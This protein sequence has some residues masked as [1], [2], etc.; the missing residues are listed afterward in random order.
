MAEIRQFDDE[1]VSLDAMENVRRIRFRDPI[2]ARA[3][4]HHPEDLRGPGGLDPRHPALV[5]LGDGPV[6]QPELPADQQPPFHVAYNLP[7]DSALTL[8]INDTAGRRVRNLVTRAAEPKGS[9]SAAWDLK[10]EEGNFVSPGGY[11]W[12]ALVCPE[13]SLRY[14]TTVN[15]TK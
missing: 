1:T 13:L 6:P 7:Q 5:N 14:E 8:A 9:G 11:R 2:A 3:A 4:D 10:D 15:G 12:T